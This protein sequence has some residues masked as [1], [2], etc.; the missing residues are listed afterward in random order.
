MATALTLPLIG[1]PISAYPLTLFLWVPALWVF[2]RASGW[3]AFILGWSTGAAATI[4]GFHWL[5]ETVQRF[6]NLP[7]PMAVAV[8]ILFGLGEGLLLGL[9]AMGVSALRNGFHRTW[10]LWVALWFTACEFVNPQLLPYFQGSVWYQVPWLFLLSALTGVAG[11]SF[12][13]LYANTVLLMLV[14]RLHSG[15]KPTL[16]RPLLFHGVSL[17]LLTLLALAWSGVRLHRIDAAEAV[18]DSLHVALIQTNRNPAES[19]MLRNRDGR[20]ALLEDHLQ[21]SRQALDGPQP[22]DVLVWP[23]AAI[24]RPTDEGWKRL[25][26]FVRDNKVE[27]WS[28]MGYWEGTGPD[29]YRA[30]NSAIRI[31]KDGQVDR[32]YDKNVLFPFG[33]YMPLEDWIPALRRIEGVG[34]LTRGEELLVFKSPLA[35]FVF[36]ICYE[37]IHSSY[38]RTG[39]RQDLDLLVNITY[40]AWYGD[41]AAPHEHLMLSAIQAAQ[42]GLPLIRAATTGLSAIVD[43]RGCITEVSKLFQRQFLVQEVK[44]VRLS[45]P[46]THLGDWFAWGSVLV[47]LGLF[48]DLYRRRQRSRSS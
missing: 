6:S 11:L 1:P 27:I 48:V 7:W 45:S 36:L 12:L 40:D 13:L 28:G 35:T 24:D 9:F 5:V 14:E 20:D 26:E 43:A 18:A 47:S 38:V 39:T 42:Y 29:S 10:P 4:A 16:H 25:R 3:R 23:E 19:H 33:E 17:A 22:V 2:S 30:F 15:D 21:L 37:A 31:Q 41:T 8:L 46:Y 34:D 44:K 32:R